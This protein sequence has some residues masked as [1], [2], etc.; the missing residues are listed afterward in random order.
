MTGAKNRRY[1]NLIQHQVLGSVQPSKWP[2]FKKPYNF[3]L[4][5]ADV[6]EV[7]FARNSTRV[8]ITHKNGKGGRDRNPRG[9]IMA[10][11]KRVSTKRRFLATLRGE[12]VKI[13]EVE[14]SVFAP[15]RRGHVACFV[16]RMS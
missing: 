10:Q 4:K 9:D 7:L 13:S 5:P 14:K 11:F 3:H 8:M 1:S 15:P 6:Q 2:I 16:C 12:S